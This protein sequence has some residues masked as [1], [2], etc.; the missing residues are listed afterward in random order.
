MTNCFQIIHY[1]LWTC[2]VESVSGFKYYLIFLDDFTQYAWVF[3]LQ[4]KSE[5]FTH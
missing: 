3:P 5:A 2:L 4:S 1:D